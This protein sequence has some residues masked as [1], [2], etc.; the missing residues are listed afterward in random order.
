MSFIDMNPVVCLNKIKNM[1]TQIISLLI[2]LITSIAFAQPIKL[3]GSIKNS[4]N[5]TL[6]LVLQGDEGLFFKDSVLLDSLGNFNYQTLKITR[7]A[8]ANLT[9]RKGIQIQLFL[10]PGYDLEIT[11]DAKDY[12]LLKRTIR[13]EGIGGKTNR[14]WEEIYK[15]VLA[16]T[17]N[18]NKK[19]LET[20]TAHL[21]KPI[22]TNIIDQVFGEE[23]KDPFKNYFKEVLLINYSWGKMIS[24]FSN[25]AYQNKLSWE[26]IQNVVKKIGMENYLETLND[27]QN[28]KSNAFTYF[29]SQYTFYC[30]TYSAYPTDSLLR[31][32]RNYALQLSDR[33]YTGDVYDFIVSER[34]VM[35]L[36]SRYKFEDLALLSPYIHKINSAERRAALGRLWDERVKK[37]E[38]FQKGVLS[39]EFTL[40]DM[41]NK[42]F[43]LADFKGKVIYIDLWASWCGPCRDENPHMLKLFA[44]YKNNSNIVL[45]SIATFDA[46][47]RAKRYEIIKK[48]RMTWLQLEDPKN[49]FAKAYQASFIP[50][51]IIIDKN[52]YIVDSDAPR[53]SEGATL[54]DI[55]EK[56]IKK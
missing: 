51:F 26:Q 27:G 44:K 3:S 11:G 29:L 39:P 33:L 37:T 40:K 18:W 2:L 24:L 23:N 10:A 38:R 34:V 52:G 48:D 47:N 41:S 4:P 56:E 21:N 12:N 25:Y 8:G 6:E 31:N 46:A 14:Y 15:N 19:D 28:L 16:D 20:Y 17:I 43:S 42:S 22:N 53:P 5:R 55:L 49:I 54:T 30:E 35:G 32:S 13:Y 1:K 9:N 7:P 45:I 50:R 36:E